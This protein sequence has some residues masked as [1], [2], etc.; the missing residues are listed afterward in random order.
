MI[1]SPYL[2]TVISALIFFPVK[3]VYIVDLETSVHSNP[4]YNFTSLETC[5]QDDPPVIL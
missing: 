4:T 1:F 5:G 3:S 2:N